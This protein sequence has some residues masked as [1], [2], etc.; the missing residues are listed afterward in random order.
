MSNSDSLVKDF[1]LE[2][3]PAHFSSGKEYIRMHK[4]QSVFAAL[5]IAAAGFSAIY[6]GKPAIE[7]LMD[8]KHQTEVR[9]ARKI[10]LQDKLQTAERTIGKTVIVDQILTDERGRMVVN[11]KQGGKL[12]GSFYPDAKEDEKRIKKGREFY[13]TFFETIEYSKDKGRNPVRG[14][15]RKPIKTLYFSDS[16]DGVPKTIVR[17]IDNVFT[18]LNGATV[19]QTDQRVPIQP[20]EEGYDPEKD[21]MRPEEF[22]TWAPKEK[23]ESLK[24]IIGGVKAGQT[25]ELIVYEFGGKE[26]VSKAWSVPPGT[27]PSNEQKVSRY[28]LYVPPANRFKPPGPAQQR[29]QSGGIVLSPSGQV[30]APSGKPLSKEEQERM[31]PEIERAKRILSELRAKG[32]APVSRSP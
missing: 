7:K 24:E 26:F 32:R 20:G 12:L 14:E 8:M 5:G 22:S 11:F 18:A 1:F 29:S 19:I 23:P 16:M 31:A 28:G 2:T 9:N 21:T 25:C 6:W 4:R 3:M 27:Q 13:I 30:L 15:I 10:R 17:K